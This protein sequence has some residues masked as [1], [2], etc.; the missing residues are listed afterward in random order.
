MEKKK[1]VDPTSSK[2]CRKP[3]QSS[4]KEQLYV[5][6]LN[7]GK[8]H[9]MQ[10]IDPVQQWVMKATTLVFVNVILCCGCRSLY[11]EEIPFQK[12]RIWLNKDIHQLFSPLTA[13]MHDRMSIC[14]P[15]PE[16]GSDKFSYTQQKLIYYTYPSSLMH[17]VLSL[18][19]CDG[20]K[21]LF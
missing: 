21:G 9:L 16:W 19:R 18:P 17:R 4:F 3:R 6:Q 15:H 13:N 2:G 11:W 14:V 8:W 20:A 10:W 12:G 1:Q 7:L 5:L